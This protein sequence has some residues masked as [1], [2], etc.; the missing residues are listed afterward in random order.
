[1]M[2]SDS[3]PRSPARL[4][5]IPGLSLRTGDLLAGNY[6]VTSLL[7]ADRACAHLAAIQAAKNG[8]PVEVQ[9]FIAM[10]DGLD[11]VRLRFVAEARKVAALQIPH[12]PE[13]LDVGVTTDG[14]PFIVRQATSSETLARHLER[15]GSLPT[16]SAVDVAIAV[17]EALAAAHA[18]GI[19]HGQL[20]PEAVRLHWTV[21]GVS[22]VELAEVGVSRAL[23]MLPL[24][25][26]PLE[27][28][29]ISPPERLQSNREADAQ[30]DIWGVG[31]LLYTMLAGATPFASDSPST[32]NLSVALDEP[33]MLAGVPDGLGDLVDAC[34]ARD[35]ALRPASMAVLASKLAAFGSRPVFEKRA[36]TLVTDTGPYEALVLEELVETAARHNPAPPAIDSSIAVLLETVQALTL[37]SDDLEPGDLE[38]DD[39]EPDDASP[40]SPVAP[41]AKAAPPAPSTPPVKAT[42]VIEPEVQEKTVPMMP[43]KAAAAPAAQA[44]ALEP[45]KTLPMVP[46]KATPKVAVLSVVMTPA[47]RVMS[48][49]VAPVA[50]SASTQSARPRSNAPAAATADKGAS[51]IAVA[52]AIACACGIVI[53]V[54]LNRFSSSP[55]AAAPPTPPPQT[56]QVAPR[57]DRPPPV[58]TAP[59]VVA[60]PQPE[61]T[62]ITPTPA[63]AVTDL[64]T[65]PTVPAAAAAPRARATS[66]APKTA[67]LPE[68]PVADPLVNAAAA[69]L[70]P[71]PKASDDDLRRYLDDRR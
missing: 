18:H 25:A 4:R 65:L 67:A 27:M 64:R 40:A 68:A 54:A 22:N 17:S 55:S 37:D 60:A 30:A 33:A 66:A 41:I 2:L 19:I 47:P 7:R 43:P 63:V 23:A 51:R 32:L 26:R 59:P 12:V 13:I 42:L 16:E 34:L 14:H 1:M 45:E 6:R 28:F 52:I 48:S 11:A 38:P 29:S 15:R 58:V 57:L 61:L 36:S 5:L 46:P 62:T 35:P 10:G 3:P 71:V 9:L 24:E 39:L 8:Q 53:G 69:P 49:T 31:V 21:E 70:H 56:V 50:M 20:G 44:R